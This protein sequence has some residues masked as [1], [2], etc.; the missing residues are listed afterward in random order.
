MRFKTVYFVSLLF[1]L[2]LAANASDWRIVDSKKNKTIFSAPGLENWTPGITVSVNDNAGGISE[3][4]CWRGFRQAKA[5]ACISYQ[6][7]P[8]GNFAYIA[9]SDIPGDFKAF[10]K[11]DYN[12]E[13]VSF[14]AVSALGEANVILGRMTHP[15]KKHCFT[16][17]TRWNAGGSVLI[18]W[19]CFAEGDTIDKNFAIKVIASLGIKGE[20]KPLSS[21]EVKHEAASESTSPSRLGDVETRLKEAKELKEEGIDTEVIPWV[22]DNDH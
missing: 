2:P 17:S 6:S 21:S 5:N 7:I 10:E 19:Y 4:K 14:S 13:G 20:T 9:A 11:I 8:G 1:F 12:T 18:G 16:H 15:K 3:W 22:N